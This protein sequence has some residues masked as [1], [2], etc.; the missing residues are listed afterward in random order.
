M[1]IMSRSVCIADATAILRRRAE[2]LRSATGSSNCHMAE[3]AVARNFGRT[4]LALSELTQTGGSDSTTTRA[5]RFLD[6]SSSCDRRHLSFLKKPRN[7]EI[8]WRGE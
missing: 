3:L 7:G 4:T 1:V 6:D 8:R 2:L 5:T